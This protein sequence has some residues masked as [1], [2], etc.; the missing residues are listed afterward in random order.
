MIPH[1]VPLEF[2]RVQSYVKGFL[3]KEMTRIGL[4]TSISG[5]EIVLLLLDP[6]SSRSE[7]VWTVLNDK[8]YSS[9]AGQIPQLHWFERSIKD[10]FDLTPL[11][12]P[13]LRSNFIQNAFDS[14]LIPLSNDNEKDSGNSQRNFRFMKVFGEGIYEVPVGPVH[15][16]IIEPGHF[17]LSCFGEYIQ[18]LEL[19]FGFLHR[20]LEKNILRMPLQKMCFAAEAASSDTAC[21]NALA[22][23]MAIESIL[24]IEVSKQDALCRNA[25]LELERAAMH[26]NDIGGMA[27]DLGC[28][29]VATTLSRLRGTVLGLAEQ[30]TGSRLIRGYIKV[31]GVYFRPKPNFRELKK[32][33][34]DIEQEFTCIVNW[35]LENAQVLER[36]SQVG[37]VSHNLAVDFG[38]VGVVARAS[39]IDYDVR[40][41]F[42]TPSFP[43]D[44]HKVAHEKDGD[45]LAR[46][47]VRT[48]ELVNSLEI[49]RFLFSEL[50]E[51]N[52]ECNQKSFLPDK[53]PTN[54]IAFGIV[55]SFRGELI[56]F[57]KTDDEGKIERYAIKDPSFNN[58]T[59]M[60][61]C[62]R[63]NLL[64]DFPVCNKSFALSYSG[65]DL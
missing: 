5:N 37:K 35:F 45:C 19:R 11:N 14:N 40:K 4:M 50:N 25:A 9:L 1:L 64:A 61:I 56:H 47:R 10:M 54:S 58:W 20:G 36:L 12:H 44:V 59:G 15:A 41:N 22:H 31:G 23:A 21:A 18:N 17:R 52:F 30:L 2:S 34:E 65:H 43:S 49:L 51:V 42:T 13:R 28:L 55:E 32:T 7:L 48:Y 24:Q 33:I 6:V 26:I 63:G 16:G 39:G 46:T 62:A 60:A 57:I 3:E 38:F 27:L 8:N 29:S 53:L